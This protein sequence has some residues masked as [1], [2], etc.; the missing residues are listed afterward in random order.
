[1]DSGA[2][3]FYLVSVLFEVR[4]SL[5]SLRMVE[6]FLHQAYSLMTEV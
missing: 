4:I 5:S 3:F 1:M 2:W 6:T